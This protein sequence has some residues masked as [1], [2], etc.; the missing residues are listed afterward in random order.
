VR[1]GRKLGNVKI[2]VVEAWELRRV[3]LPKEIFFSRKMLTI[4]VG[5]E[6]IYLN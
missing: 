1:T 2:I 5:K 6:G 4:H 3:G